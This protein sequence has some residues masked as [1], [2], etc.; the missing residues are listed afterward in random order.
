M[1]LRSLRNKLKKL[2]GKGRGTVELWIKM[3]DGAWAELSTQDDSNTLDWLGLEDNSH[4]MY[5][6]TN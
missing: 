2:K 4:I 5:Q 3:R 6:L 1:P